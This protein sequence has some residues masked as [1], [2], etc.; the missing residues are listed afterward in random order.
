MMLGDT[1]EKSLQALVKQD[2]LESAKT[3]KLNFCEHCVIGKKTKVKFGNAIHCTKGIFDYGHVDVWGLFKMGSIGGNHY[4]VPFID[5]YSRRCWV[6]TMRHKGKV[7]KLF[8]E[9]KKYGEEYKKEDQITPFRGD[10]YQ[11]SFPTTMS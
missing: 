9:R 2:L 3:F 4:F 7:L 1:G 11:Q 5:D 6:Y 10:D 8:V